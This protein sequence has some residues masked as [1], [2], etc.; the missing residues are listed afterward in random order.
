MELLAKTPT[1][2]APAERFTGDVRVDM[3]AQG[4]PP[5]AAG[6]GRGAVRTLRPHRLAPA[7]PRPDAARHLRARPRGLP[8]RHGPRAAPG[9]HRAHP[10]RRV[11]LARRGPRPLHGPPRPVRVRRRPG[12]ALSSGCAG[13]ATAPA[14]SAVCPASAARSPSPS[15]SPSPPRWT[16]AP[17]FPDHDTIVFVTACVIVL[18]LVVQ[19]ALLPAVVRW[20]HLSTD[21]AAEAELR[22]AETTATQDALAA[23]WQISAP[24]REPRTSFATNSDAT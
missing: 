16:T 23:P 6:G 5:V 13:S 18:T 17:P 7:H 4:M 14:S 21:T 9:R 19:G 12:P 8:R 1:A 10:S 2:K 15:C 3:L 24:A 22:L 11:A 20:A